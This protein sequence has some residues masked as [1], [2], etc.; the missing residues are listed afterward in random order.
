[1]SATEYTGYAWTKD[2]DGVVTV[3]MDDPTSAVN[4]MNAHFEHAFEATID[5]LEAEREEI[6]G[7]ILTSAKRSWFA[8]GDLA[9]LRAADP[10]KAAA[11]TAH[12][13]HGKS[14]L[15]RL[16]R[17]GRPVV[18][19]LNG[20]A[21][22]GGLE[23]AL[24]AHHR[25]AAG[26]AVDAR[27]GLPEVSLG[28]L[29]GGGGVTRTVRMLGLQKALQEVILPA[30][31]F[32]AAD[33]LAVGIIDEI[34]PFAELDAA[35]RAW[36]AANPHPVKPWDE[37]GF[38]LPGGSP[39]SPAIAGMLPMLPALLRK[40][41]RG[42]PM[43]AP[44]AALAAAVEGAYLDFDSASTVETRYFV[45][46]THT[47]VAKNMIKAFFFDP[48][49]LGHTAARAVEPAIGAYV[50]EAITAVGEGVEPASV[51]QAALQAGF[52][53]SALRLL[54]DRG[55]SALGATGH[56]AEA[57]VRWMIASAGR[58]GRAAGGGF[59]EY[60]DG[61]RIR[62]WPGLRERFGSGRT[63]LPLIQLQE[64]MLFADAL[65]AIRRR[66]S[67]T[68][69]S[70]AEANLD[71]IRGIGFPPWTGGAL[72]YANQYTG[73]LAGFTARAQELTAAYGERFQPSPA[74]IARA[75]S[76]EEYR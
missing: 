45:S 18:A 48:Q 67:G 12:I 34:V 4:T 17:L 11:E 5:R 58:H 55:L 32:D 63:V 68:P 64:R 65:A 10:A 60:E 73:G 26:D 76:G 27:F 29:P 50:A 13:E 41:L 74:L 38:R 56:P 8:G 53:T 39:S 47:Q 9:L 44:R 15:R 72:Q 61:E 69:S 42:A 75:A 33:A 28:L 66:E 70:V 24:T 6:A 31:R 62:I 36:I 59:Y 54:D 19:T 30:R 2:A 23:I 7:V 52:A 35:A 49:E 16:E 57:V 40:Q 20:T 14:V 22:G 25:I 51:E 1:M 43:P 3:T 37:K 21:L 71:S 46:L